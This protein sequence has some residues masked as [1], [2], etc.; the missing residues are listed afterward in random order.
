MSCS[1]SYKQK[2]PLITVH[3]SLLVAGGLFFSVW[4][5]GLQNKATQLQT[6][7]RT[8]LA[9]PFYWM[10]LRRAD[11][12]KPPTGQAL[13]LTLSPEDPQLKP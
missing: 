11:F 13:K 9:E 4:L 7:D 5:W 12:P 10:P 1:C 3:Q 6:A 8:L 2:V